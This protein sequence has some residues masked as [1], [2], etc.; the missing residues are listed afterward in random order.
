V[1]ARIVAD[2]AAANPCA[3]GLSEPNSRAA[4]I[5]IDEVDAGCLECP[6]DDIQSGVS[7]FAC[8]GLPLV[9][10]SRWSASPEVI[11]GTR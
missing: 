7:R 2:R 11:P 1:P 10:R 8:T 3:L 9:N 5:G 4:S 6:P